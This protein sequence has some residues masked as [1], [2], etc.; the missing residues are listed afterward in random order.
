MQVHDS[1]LK[2][3]KESNEI[4]QKKIETIHSTNILIPKE[5]K[6]ADDEVDPAF[7]HIQEEVRQLH[8]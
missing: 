1:E 8:Y 7:K 2:L 4:Y 6:G 3:V 5:K